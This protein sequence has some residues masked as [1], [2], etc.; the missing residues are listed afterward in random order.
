MP[1]ETVFHCLGPRSK[2]ETSP[3]IPSTQPNQVSGTDSHQSPRKSAAPL[4]TCNRSKVFHR[5]W[6]RS[7]SSSLFLSDH[8]ESPSLWGIWWDRAT[9]LDQFW[10]TGDLRHPRIFEALWSCKSTPTGKQP[11]K[12]CV[13]IPSKLG[14]MGVL[15]QIVVDPPKSSKIQFVTPHC[16]IGDSTSGDRL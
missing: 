6:K 16:P 14:N 10:K 15:P 11:M 5:P 4:P 13:W 8:G 12:W 9:F 2:S 3:V 1:A 7:E